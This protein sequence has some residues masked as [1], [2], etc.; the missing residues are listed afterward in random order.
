MITFFVA[1]LTS[2]IVGAVLTL[3]VRNRAHAYGWFD[4]ARSSRKIHARPIPRLGGLA[5]AHGRLDDARK[6]LDEALH[7]GVA[8]HSTH[9]LATSLVAFAAL[10]LAQ[11]DAERAA[12]LMGASEMTVETG[13]EGEVLRVTPGVKTP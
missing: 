9:V 2:L 11:G 1:F 12:L 7:L 8:W 3:V 6:L 10:A 4:Q 13:V 5:I